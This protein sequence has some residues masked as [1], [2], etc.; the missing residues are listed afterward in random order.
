M[1]QLNWTGRTVT[2]GRS[3]YRQQHSHRRSDADLELDFNS[4]ASLLD[5]LLD[6]AETETRPLPNWL[7]REI[8]V[9]RSPKHFVRHAV[10]VVRD[11]D[12][13]HPSR[14]SWSRHTVLGRDCDLAVVLQRCA[15]IA[16]QI[17]ECEVKVLWILGKIG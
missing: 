13:Y 2:V 8:G 4:A 3:R 11:D 9:E 1:L 15:R 17:E 10:S 14:S 12:F 16:A 5:K 7:R 6:L